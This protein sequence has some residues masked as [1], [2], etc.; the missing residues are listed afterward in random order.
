MKSRILAVLILPL[1]LGGCLSVLPEPEIPVAL[2]ALPAELAKTPSD[3]LR[4]DVAVYPPDASRAYSGLDMA[5]RTGQELV[6]LANVRWVD[7]APRLLQGAVVD[8]LARAGGDGRAAPAQLGARVDYD[9]RWR[10]I[11]LSAGKETAPVNAVVEVSIL[12]A[13]TRRMIAQDTFKATD[14]PASREPRARAAAMATAA[15]SVADQVAEFVAKSVTPKP[16]P[17]SATPS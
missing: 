1:A 3:P 15:Q 13:A 5:V 16:A 8:A 4:A 6:Y 17:A 7:T 14:N 9:V 12:D 2:I 11:D 10:I